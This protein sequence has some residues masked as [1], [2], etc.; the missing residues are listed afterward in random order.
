MKRYR[1]LIV[2]VILVL[3]LGG[4]GYGSDPS[5]V[6]VDQWEIPF[7]NAWTGPAAGYGILCDY[8]QKTAVEE[9]NAAG[10]I[11][12][13]PLV[14]KPCDT[15]MDPTRSASCMKQ[16]MDE[17]LIVL[18]PMTSLAA[19]ICAP[20]AARAEV[21]CLPPICGVETIQSARPWAVALQ[22]P[23]KV[24][25]RFTLKTWFDMYPDIGSVVMLGVPKVA[26]WKALGVQQER[27][28]EERGIKVLD[29]IDVAAG[30]VDYASVVIRA[31][32]ARP[33]A[34]ILRVF[35]PDTVRLVSELENRGFKDKGKI[36]AH[37]SA[38]SPE[39][40]TMSAQSGGV[41][42]GVHIGAFS[43]ALNN[44][45]Y[46]KLLAGMKK[47]K[48]QEN[49]NKLMW[50]DTFYV[51]TYMIKEAIEKTGV[52]GDPDKRKAERAMLKDYINS[53]KDFDSRIWGR[54]SAQPDGSFN[55]P[56]YFG[57]IENNQLKYLKSSKD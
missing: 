14:M 9:I 24:R 19:Q 52:T 53:V 57:V 17:S 37:S 5:R 51:S 45:S 36:F 1:G 18:G 10:G 29:D 38:D 48:G 11:A 20:V 7:L 43:R 26:Q 27:Y 13:K 23:N 2:A 33:D 35:P 49:A 39:M 4:T 34:I 22:T 28:C 6:V 15:S 32:K 25:A 55:L 21:F 50:G 42:N 8:F 46:R 56:L 54:I 12:G 47:M 40:Y 41:M 30:G 31:L 16:A 3:G 44:D